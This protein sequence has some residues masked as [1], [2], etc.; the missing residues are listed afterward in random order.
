VGCLDS[1]TLVS[2]IPSEA[3]RL[4]LADYCRET[5]DEKYAGGGL[6]LSQTYSNLREQRPPLSESTKECGTPTSR[7]LMGDRTDGNLFKF[8]SILSLLVG[9]IIRG[10]EVV[11][12]N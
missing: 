8:F 10:G 5:I 11:F 1:C 6:E 3:S 2:P 9:R 12:L 7:K 4:A